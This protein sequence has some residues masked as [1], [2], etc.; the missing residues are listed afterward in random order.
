M[1]FEDHFGKPW[2]DLAGIASGCLKTQSVS[3]PTKV[4]QPFVGPWPLVGHKS[5][6]SKGAKIGLRL[7]G[8]SGTKQEL[9]QK[10]NK[11]PRKTS[12]ERHRPP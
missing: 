3:F 6:K 5:G 1:A 12:K 10:N 11:K 2:L 4:I 7:V 9:H 8:P